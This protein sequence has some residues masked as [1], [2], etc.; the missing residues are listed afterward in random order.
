MDDLGPFSELEETNILPLLWSIDHNVPEHLLGDITRL[1]QVLINLCTNS[2][3]FTQRGRVSVRVSVHRP[4]PQYPTIRPN[5]TP[6]ITRNSPQGSHIYS[7]YT[8]GSES[9]LPSSPMLSGSDHRPPMVFQQRYDVRAEAGSPV[10]HKPSPAP[11]RRRQADK[12]FTPLPAATAQVSQD[13]ESSRQATA[14]MVPS[15]TV[16]A[17]TANSLERDAMDE[18]SVILEFSV[19]D[20]GVGIPANKITELFTSFSQV[21]ISVSTRFGGTGLGLAISA[22]LVEKMGGNIWV[23][24][25]E[26]VGSRFTFTIPFTICPSSETDSHP[27]AT[28][29][30]SPVSVPMR[31]ETNKIE[32]PE[33]IQLPAAAI[34]PLPSALSAAEPTEDAVLVPKTPDM[35]IN[36]VETL[37]TPPSSSSSSGKPT[38]PS[39]AKV[40]ESTLRPLMINDVPLRILL[41]EDNQG[42]LRRYLD[43]Y[44]RTDILSVSFNLHSCFLR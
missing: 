15:L 1:R 22:S 29:P 12:R 4:T 13:R 2:L 38:M 23:E 11:S 7:S 37:V 20:T 8:E 34:E 33:S 39:Y 6:T 10:H 27:S 30:P 36:P 40:V 3:K 26:G 44:L 32:V 25:T 41:A 9:S 24:S 31:R 28:A 43:S 18:N 21:D 16:V 42:K 17:P 35:V 19:S 14:F 5:C